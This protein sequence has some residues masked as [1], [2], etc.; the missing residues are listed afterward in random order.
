[1]PASRSTVRKPVFSIGPLFNRYQR[2]K[3]GKNGDCLFRQRHLL[4][5]R[6]SCGG[7]KGLS[8]ETMDGV[9]DLVTYPR[10]YGGLEKWMGQ[11]SELMN[12]IGQADSVSNASVK[13]IFDALEPTIMSMSDGIVSKAMLLFTSKGPR[14]HWEKLRAIC[15][16]LQKFE[17]KLSSNSNELLSDR[18]GAVSD[19]LAIY[20]RA[21][22]VEEHSSQPLDSP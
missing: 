15:T 9:L 19:F 17:G 7:G 20:D 4:G 5:V 14:N 22:T 12:A 13:E 2:K 21:M 10:K 6:T 8:E 11:V 3:A 18:I 16:F 1:M